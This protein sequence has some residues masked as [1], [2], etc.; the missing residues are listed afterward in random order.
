[1]KKCQSCAM[2][3]SKDPKGGGSNKDGTI[4][5]EYCSLCYGDGAFYYQGGD[6]K[7]FQR[8]VYE[9]LQEHGWWR[10][11]AWLATREIPR[12]KRWK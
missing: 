4:S 12:L 6:S 8:F 5:D 9:K 3:M 11:V 1:M 10:P 7:A 2:P